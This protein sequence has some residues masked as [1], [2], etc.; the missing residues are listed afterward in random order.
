MASRQG[1][2]SHVSFDQLTEAGHGPD[3]PSL[4]LE[5]EKKVKIEPEEQQ[6][7]MTAKNYQD[8]QLKLK[9]LCKQMGL[10]VHEALVYKTKLQE[11][12]DQGKTYLHP[13]LELLIQQVT[14]FQDATNTAIGHSA[15][16]GEATAAAVAALEKQL[17]EANTHY[18]AFKSGGLQG[19][20]GHLQVRLPLGQPGWSSATETDTGPTGPEAGHCKTMLLLA[21]L[22]AVWCLHTLQKESLEVLQ[23]GFHAVDVLQKGFHAAQVLQKDLC[24]H[25]EKDP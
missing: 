22:P 23:K 25:F 19:C 18:Q 3:R 6:G 2:I 8:T 12:V 17:Q 5:D 24:L 13:I 1:K 15:T 16:G 7:A 14:I 10:L 4:A 9:K 11:R 21:A 20:F